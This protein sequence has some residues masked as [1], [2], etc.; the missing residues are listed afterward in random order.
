MT[1]ELTL[2]VRTSVCSFVCL[3]ASVKIKCQSVKIK[4]AR[5][6]TNHTVDK[7]V[8]WSIT[9]I[10]ITGFWV[11]QIG[12]KSNQNSHFDHIVQSAV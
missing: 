2:S 7:S 1:L 6:P 10:G 4:E 12:Y 5:L 11:F 8:L 9:F 3:S